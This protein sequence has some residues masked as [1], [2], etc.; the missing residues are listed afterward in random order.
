MTGAGPFMVILSTLGA[1]SCASFEHLL[2]GDFLAGVR[3]PAGHGGNDAGL[4]R[5]AFTS[6]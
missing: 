4:K 1:Y 2:V 6:L 3:R 5:R